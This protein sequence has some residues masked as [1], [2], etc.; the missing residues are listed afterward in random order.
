[1]AGRVATGS[2]Q[3]RPG[4]AVRPSASAPTKSA[5][6]RSSLGVYRG[7]DDAWKATAAGQ[8]SDWDNSGGAAP[9]GPAT[10][11]FSGGAAAFSGG[12][13]SEPTTAVPITPPPATGGSGGSLR[14]LQRPSDAGTAMNHGN[15]PA[16]RFGLG[17]RTPPSLAAILQGLRY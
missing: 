2:M 17:Q 7:D 10:G 1:M 12:G 14:A 6:V 9:A 13:A 16:L 11:G 15:D 8:L 4:G 3:A 5:P